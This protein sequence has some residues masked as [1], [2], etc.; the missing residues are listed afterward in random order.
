MRKE[1]AILPCG[2]PSG[3][4]HPVVYSV[5]LNWKDAVDRVANWSF[6]LYEYENGSASP[7]N[8]S[9]ESVGFFRKETTDNLDAKDAYRIR[10]VL[11]DDDG[12]TYTTNLLSA[13]PINVQ[14]TRYQYWIYSE[15]P[16]PEFG[17]FVIR[18]TNQTSTAWID[19]SNFDPASAVTGWAR[20]LSSSW[21][22]EER[23]A[24]YPG[25]HFQTKPDSPCP[26]CGESLKTTI[27][28]YP[29]VPPGGERIYVEPELVA[30][31]TATPMLV[32]IGN[33]SGDTTE[34]GSSYA[35]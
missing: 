24:Y 22:L 9:M 12:Q 13:T 8:V 5:D 34:G 32:S 10:V 18:G 25:I 2:E 27:S 19:A 31:V 23:V 30:R 20:Y 35:P 3:T 11:T 7:A 21:P 26:I 29:L 14:G 6:Q 4:S 28:L 15:I 16:W 17:E 1:Q 33:E